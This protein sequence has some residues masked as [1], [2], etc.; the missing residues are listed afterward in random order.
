MLLGTNQIIPQHLSR[1]SLLHLQMPLFHHFLHER[2][3]QQLPSASPL[4][5]IV[6]EQDMIASRDEFSYVRPGP[7]G[8]NGRLLVHEFL[9]QTTGGDDCCG[10]CS[11]LEG[12]DTAILFGPFTELK[13]CAFLWDLMDVA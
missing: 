4:L 3:V 7:L 10:S 5:A 8:V 9:D 2:P 13:V 1:L 6:H 12:I 11:E